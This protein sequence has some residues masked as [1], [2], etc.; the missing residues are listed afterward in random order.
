MCDGPTVCNSSCLIALKAIGQLE[1]LNQLYETVVIPDAVLVECGG[2]LPDWCQVVTMSSQPLV[3][4][5]R[6]HVGLG[7]SEAIALTSELSAIR[8]ILDD[9]KARRMARQMSL[10]VTGTLAVLLRARQE[11][12]IV[13]VKDVID[14]LGEVNFFLS[15][16]LIDE[17]LRRAGE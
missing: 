11:S 12:L 16:E 4:S 17:V 10:P 13:S 3:A 14:D 1:L 2:S 5:L 9:K 6:M 15:D 8:I 7:E